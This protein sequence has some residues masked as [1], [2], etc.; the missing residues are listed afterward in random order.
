MILIQLV[1][2][3]PEI[4]RYQK[5]YKV[6]SY[7]SLIFF[8]SREVVKQAILC[9]Q[10]WHNIYM[11]C[12]N[13]AFHNRPFILSHYSITIHTCSMP[14]VSNYLFDWNAEKINSLVNGSIHSIKEILN[15]SQLWFNLQYVY[16]WCEL[17]HI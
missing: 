4:C 10:C 6:F 14:G 11:N 5:E 7:N 15:W 16:L 3:C 17:F 13:K 9:R 8:S 2:F 12:I 1:N